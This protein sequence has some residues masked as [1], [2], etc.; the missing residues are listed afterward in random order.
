MVELKSS[1]VVQAMLPVI[2][3]SPARPDFPFDLISTD[4][5]TEN[6]TRGVQLDPT[7]DW[8]AVTRQLRMYATSCETR[9]VLVIDEGVAIYFRFPEDPSDENGFHEYLYA[10]TEMGQSFVGELRLS[11]RE[12][13]VFVL[14]SAFESHNIELLDPE[15][16]APRTILVGPNTRPY[17]NVLPTPALTPD[18]K[19]RPRSS[20]GQRHQASKRAMRGDPDPQASFE[21]MVVGATLKL[22]LIRSKSPVCTGRQRGS[23]LDSGFHDV[24]NSFPEARVRPPPSTDNPTNAATVTVERLLKPYVAVVTDGTTRFIAK[25][26]PPHSAADPER[27]LSRELAVYRECSDLQGGYIPY[28]HGVY[29]A[30]RRGPRFSSPIMLTEFVGTGKTIADL[31]ALAGVL[32]DDDELDAAEKALAV[33]QDRALDA[34]AALHQRTIVHSDL[35]GANMLVVDKDHVVLVDFGY[36]MVLKDAARRFKSRSK[37]DLRRLKQAFEVRYD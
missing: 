30:V 5:P 14:F 32:D 36:S 25:L 27:M 21:R 15:A 19:K 23:S 37:E 12:L 24:S 16:D 13:V 22:E 20:S 17:R 31:V 7:D 11:L 2:S 1:A 33:L 29:R 6:V 10:S 3:L 9:D 18:S 28:L 8:Q 35:G 26:F 34:L 4:A